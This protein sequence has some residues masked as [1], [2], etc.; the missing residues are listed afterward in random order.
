MGLTDA[1]IDALDSLALRKAV[2]EAVSIGRTI[3]KVMCWL[4]RCG[5]HQWVPHIRESE[6]MVYKFRW[7]SRCGL[8]QVKCDPYW[9][10]SGWFD[11]TDHTNEGADPRPES[12]RDEEW[13]KILAAKYVGRKYSWE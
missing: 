8:C 9:G 11:I 1:E 7:C 12:W 10:K 5:W 2:A 6:K 3:E 4:C 13:A